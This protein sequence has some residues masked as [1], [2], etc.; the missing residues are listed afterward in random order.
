MDAEELEE[1]AYHLVQRVVA[2]VPGDLGQMVRTVVAP[3]VPQ[4]TPAFAL[5]DNPI[6][7]A[8]HVLR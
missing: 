2:A 5:P 6:P 3:N 4:G 1:A 8:P 7:W